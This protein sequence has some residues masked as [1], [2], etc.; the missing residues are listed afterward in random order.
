M[1]KNGKLGLGSVISTGVGLIVATSC[2]MSLGQGAGSVGVVFIIAMIVACALNMLT[3][4]SLA[5]LN[6][7]MPNL[8][9]GLA[10]YTLACMGPFPTIVSMIGGYLVCNSLAAS[11]EAA[12]FGNVIAEISG[13]PIPPVILSISLII[14]LIIVNMFGVDMFAKIQ[15][16]VAYSLIGSLVFMGILGFVKGG[17]GEVIEQPAALTTDPAD[18]FSMVSVAFWLFIG[19]EFIIPLAKDVR[20]PKKNIPKGMIISLLIVFAMQTL[21]VLGFSNYTPW[22][23]LASSVA[24]HLLYGTNLLG[25]PG[26]IWMSIVSVLAAVSTLNSVLSSLGHICHGMSKLGMLPEIFGK[27]NRFGAPVFGILL[28]GGGVFGVAASGMATT[29]QISFVLLIGSVFWM[30]S[31]IIAHCNVLIMRKRMPKAPR[32]FKVPLVPIVPIIGIIGTAYMIITISSDP[33][34]RNQI[35]L[36]SAIIF[37]LLGVYAVLWIKLKM[38]IPVFKPVPIEKVM[39]MEHDLYII[40]HKDTKPDKPINSKKTS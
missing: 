29:D 16:I 1:N 9:G 6:A 35:W 18:I 17:T 33:E 24:P 3:A 15:D 19:V 22:S 40:A 8:S 36:L 26:R 11:V 39:A 27:T 37:A 34:T 28:I 32:S 31:Y 23:E 38:K 30:V 5:E 2:L 12:M 4:M 10:Q 21:M 25:T 14:L 20:N 13:L 7:L